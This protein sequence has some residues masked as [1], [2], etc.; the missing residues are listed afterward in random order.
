MQLHKNITEHSLPKQQTFKYKIIHELPV[1]PETQ[2]LQTQPTCKAADL[3]I[4][5]K[6]TTVCTEAK[7]SF[8]REAGI[9]WSLVHWK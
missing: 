4:R 7:T 3:L 1:C 6:H 8:S 5:R 9:L 2:L